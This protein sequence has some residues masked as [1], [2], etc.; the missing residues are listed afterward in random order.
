MADVALARTGRTSDRCAVEA[1]TP[2]GTPS[3][4]SAPAGGSPLPASVRAPMESAFDRD[5]SAVRVHD[6][7]AD[8]RRARQLSARAFA[9]RGHIWLG[10]GQRAEDLPLLAHELAHVVQQTDRSGRFDNL[11]Q[12]QPDPNAAP[13]PAPTTAAGVESDQVLAKVMESINAEMAEL[14]PLVARLS[15][16]VPI[17]P[18]NHALNEVLNLQGRLRAD[19]KALRD[20]E[21]VAGSRA[22]DVHNAVVRLQVMQQNLSPAVAAAKTWHAANPAGESLGMMNERAGVWLAGAASSQWDKGGLHYVSG[23][24]AYAG[25]FGMAFLDAAEKVASMG[26]HDAATA[27]SQAY[28]RGDISWN[29][30]ERILRSAAW[31]ALLIAAVTRGAGMATSRLG[32]LGAEATG[33]ASTTLRYGAVAGAIPG[34]FSAVA[35][36]GTQALLTKGLED[37]FKS[38]A[39]KA[40][41]NQGMPKGK[42]W[43]IAIPLGI[44]MGGLGGMRGVELSNEK[45]VGTTIS[46]PEGPMQVVAVTQL[47][48]ATTGGKVGLTQP[49]VMVLKPVGSRVG[50]LPP[51]PAADVVMVFDPARNAWVSPQA[52]TTGLSTAPPLKPSAPAGGRSMARP[53]RSNPAPSVAPTRGLAGASAP[54]LAGALPKPVIS[55]PTKPQPLMLWPG[56]RPPLMLPSGPLA[57][58]QLQ[59]PTYE[60]FGDLGQELAQTPGSSFGTPRVWSVTPGGVTFL[61]PPLRGVPL[62]APEGPLPP[63]SYFTG[64]PR[65]WTLSGDLQPNFTPF[66]V[67]PGQSNTSRSLSQVR[68]ARG[69]N[70]RGAAGELHVSELSPGSEREVTLDLPGGLTRRSDVLSPTVPGTV[71]QEVKNYLRF[72]GSNSGAREV[73]WT[74]FMQTEINRDAM[75]IYYYGHQ[76]VWVFTDAPPSLTLRL[77][78]D[79]A[80]IP[81]V[82]ST[83]RLPWP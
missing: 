20:F 59:P 65:N 70:A 18:A 80:G 76:P 72:R 73:E 14:T 2:S 11:I 55:G 49:G 23:G 16:E 69:P 10:E 22:T 15:V 12:R 53:I 46:T 48:V 4:S 24:L 41:W 31:R 71:N 57:P 34:G 66:D 43:A 83:D 13:V 82:V 25:A 68:G 40:I 78:L 75:T 32:V 44:I 17:F 29:E 61:T 60:N 28:T 58:L 7:A 79:R 77:A 35:G 5:F 47:K 1:R 30:G 6:T 27:V 21:A 67:L 63:S 26:Y 54:A 74:P 38:P 9:H 39:A 33:L 52:R 81:Y 51:P 50:V 42:D 62:Y 64:Q 3:A 36:L 45:L 19:E 8:R 37:Q 56:L